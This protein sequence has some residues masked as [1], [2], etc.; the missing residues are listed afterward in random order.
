MKTNRR[1]RNRKAFS[2]V[3]LMAVLV[4]MGLLATAVVL[5]FAGSVDKARAG[6]TKTN[7]KLLH[8]AVLNFKMDTG[9]YPSEEDG[10][11]A[12][13]E[14]PTDVSGWTT[15][16]YLETTEIT[17]DGWGNEFIYILNPESGKAFAIKSY[18]ADG[19]D[20]GEEDSLDEDLY[21]TDA[22]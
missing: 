16:G 19:E 22:D 20:G 13:I 8:N 3:E 9:K 17:K 11:M 21:S 5:N 2:M 6:T 14:Q 4:I 12:L 10:L 1:N 15:G 7:L 18:G